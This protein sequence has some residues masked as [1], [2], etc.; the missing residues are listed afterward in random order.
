[1]AFRQYD[2]I[3]IQDVQDE[4]DDKLAISSLLDKVYPVGTIYMSLNDVSPSS[5]IGGSWEPLPE[6]KALWTASSGLSITN[7]SVNIIGAGLPNIIGNLGLSYTSSLE[8][9]WADD[10]ALYL[11]Y[12]AEGYHTQRLLGGNYGDISFNARRYNSVYGNS[13]TVQPPAYKVYAWKRT[14]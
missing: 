7:D 8:K 1:M 11:N 6:G 4:L 13:T 9:A 3:T 5:F 14:A 12:F 2:P 10:S